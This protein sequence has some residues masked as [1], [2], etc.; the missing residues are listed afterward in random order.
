LSTT[1]HTSTDTL[2][3]L[4]RLLGPE[5]VADMSRPLT[6][7]ELTYVETRLARFDGDVAAAAGVH[8]DADT[9]A[10]LQSLNVGARR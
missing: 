3:W 9:A 7:E 4:I 1:A 5:A 8:V 6:A 2:G 10:Y